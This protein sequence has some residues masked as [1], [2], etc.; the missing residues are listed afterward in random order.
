MPWL[1]SADVVTRYDVSEVRPQGAYLA[2]RCPVRAQLDVLRPCEPLGS[3]PSAQRRTER[4]I[5]FQAMALESILALHPGTAVVSADSPT[6]RERLTLLAMSAGVP[7]IA[8]GRL[9]VDLAGRRAGE[10]DL[11][12]RAGSQSREA[13]PT[14]RAVEVKAHS[15]QGPAA[16]GFAA[17][18][19][20][21]SSPRWEDA[22]ERP[23]T[24]AR[25]R[26]SDMLQL[27]HYQRML[28]A[29]GFGAPGPASGGV[30]GTEGDVAWYDL[31][32][33]LWTTPSASARTKLRST[34]EVYDFEFDFRLDIMVVAAR[35]LAEASVD[36]VVVPVR[37]V[38]CAT[39]PW[40]GHCSTELSAGAGNVS[41]LPRSGWKVFRAHRDHGVADLADLAGLDYRT[42]GLVAAKVDLRPLLAAVGELPGSTPVGAVIGDKKKAQLA[43][44]AEAGVTVLADARGLCAR[45]ASYC[46]EPMA[47]LAEQVDMARARL[48]PDPAYRRRGVGRVEVRRADVE[49][50]VDMEN[51]ED[52]VYLWGV[53]VSD[54]SAAGGLPTGYRAFVTW[55]SLDAAA[56]ARLF[57]RFWA[58]F[59]AL[60][61]EAAARRLSLCAY[62]YN[63]AAEDT[64]MRRI[65]D[66]LGL[67]QEVEALIAS[68]QWV[69]LLASFDSQLLTGTS[70]G[71]KKAAPLSGFSW[72]VDDPGG[73][74]SMLR[75]DEAVGQDGAAAAAAREW[76]LTYNRNDVE[77]T[78]AL[79]SWLEREAS[80]CPPVES[81]G[82]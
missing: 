36:L 46:D 69:D 33:P 11:L 73:E 64:Q 17:V 15:V 13:R 3:S 43:R 8:G 63:E 70:V 74:L 61:T 21:L 57:G 18:W 80:A 25:K 44:L 37:T 45:T 7:L 52:G 54:R 42:A 29:C 78:A 51:V 39:C 68:D 72:E 27:A 59:E 34:L 60:R 5:A 12:V 55:D 76:L 26:R 14:Y 16:A 65:A 9:P 56:E 23:G 50:D 49:V 19:S 81:L 22:E 1:R 38:E 4:G 35:H 82:P 53:L 77:A 79:R 66:R 31:E 48:G 24:S 67:R 75:Y 6:E 28:E 40:D 58:W 2:S 62:C 32:A 47:G 30:I 20:R 10:P 71:L 41:L